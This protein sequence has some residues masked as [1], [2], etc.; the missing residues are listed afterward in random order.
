MKFIKPTAAVEVTRPIDNARSSTEVTPSSD[1]GQAL[2]AAEQGK[3]WATYLGNTMA[4][5]VLT[6]MLLHVEDPI[7]KDILTQAHNVSNQ[8]SQTT[9][10]ILMKEEF[11]VPI[12]FTE[13]DLVKSAPR[14]FA[15]EFYLHYLKYVGKAGLSMYSIAVPLVSRSDVRTFF[16]QCVTQTLELMNLVNEGLIAK[17]LMAK[18][19]Y[20]PYPERAEFIQ[21]QSYLNGFFGDVRPLQAMEITHLYDN[22]ENTA[23]SKAVLIAFSQ[24]ANSEQA[25]AYFLR[26]KEIAEKHHA[27]FTRFLEKENLAAPPIIDHFVT[28]STTSPFSD[29]LMLFHKLDMF[30][31]RIRTYGNALSMSARHDIA[32]KYARFL[33]Q[34]GDYVE[35]GA[36]ILIEHEWLEQPP[37]AADRDAL[38]A[39][40]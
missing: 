36:N 19:P 15:D 9:K 18:P 1:I 28:T 16:T 7:I 6:H 13:A 22:I 31:M 37:Q 8:F 33:I 11:P 20:T 25:K 23:T 12:G 27:Q 29:K 5:C 40:K 35:D 14:L 2:T 3:L 26:G 10:D 24:V 34:V 38:A 32:A 4:H 21:K 17:G 39:K 30:T